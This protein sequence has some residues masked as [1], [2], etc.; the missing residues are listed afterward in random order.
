MEGTAKALSEM[1]PEYVGVLTLEVHPDTPLEAW[2]KDGSFELLDSTEVLQETRR[3]VELMDC[4]GCVF[5]MNHAS[6]YLPL[7]GT[8]NEDR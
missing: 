7:A 2:V 5:R 6:N 8:F 1:D 3:L 4:P